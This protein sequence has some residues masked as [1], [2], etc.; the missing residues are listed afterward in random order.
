M[1]QTFFL[2][3]CGFFIS[4]CKPGMFHQRIYSRTWGKKKTG[5]QKDLVQMSYITECSPQKC[6]SSPWKYLL[7]VLACSSNTYF[8]YDPQ[9]SDRGQKTKIPVKCTCKA[10]NNLLT[11]KCTLF[12]IFFLFLEKYIYPGIPH[13]CLWMF[14]CYL[15]RAQKRWYFFPNSQ[16]LG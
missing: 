9:F 6:F 14:T 13:F 11:W 12:W 4:V 10:W 16:L 15:Y 5:N 2:S 8:A 3:I 1:P 7:V